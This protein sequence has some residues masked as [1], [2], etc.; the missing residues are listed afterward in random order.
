MLLLPYETIIYR[1]KLSK[2]EVLNR[3]YSAIDTDSLWT[4]NFWKTCD[5]KDYFGDIDDDS[6]S[7]VRRIRG[8]NSFLPVILG[9]IT[10]GDDSTIISVTMRLHIMIMIV[11]FAIVS[12]IAGGAMS[13]WSS[14]TGNALPLLGAIAFI[15]L[16]TM[17]AFTMEKLRSKED[18]E[19]I[20]EAEII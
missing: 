12:I 10:E 6:F 16:L 5:D 18:L 8:R 2:Q 15:Y 14:D 7:I 19:R 1:T 17:V 3:L 9:D 20:L 4:L 11:F 13:A